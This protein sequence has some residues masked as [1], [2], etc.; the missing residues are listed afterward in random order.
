MKNINKMIYLLAAAAIAQFIFV[1]ISHMGGSTLN[2]HSNHQ[3]VLA[4]DK[5]HVDHLLIE[6]HAQDDKSD[7]SDKDADAMAVR[8]KKK[9]G[10]WFTQAGIPVTENKV[11]HLLEKLAGLKQD[12]PVATSS[13]ALKRFK[14][15]DNDYERL[16][17]L[18]NGD[19]KL[20]ALYLGRGA[21][22]RQT[23]VRSDTQSAVYTVELGVYDVPV[24]SEDWQDKNLLKLSTHE[25]SELK[26]A[27]ITFKPE[28]TPEQTRGTENSSMT[29]WKTSNLPVDKMINQKAIN[30]NLSKLASLSF[31]KILGKEKKTEYGLDKPALIVSLTHKG[32]SREYQFAK[33]NDKED[34][35]LKVSDMEEYFQ[36]SSYTA[37]PLVEGISKA[38]WFM[39]KP[40]DESDES[41]E[42]NDKPKNEPV[43]DP[44]ATPETSKTSDNTAKSND[45]PKSEPVSDP[46][47]TPET[48]KT[49]DNTAKSNDKPKSEPVSD[50]KATPETSKTPDNTAKSNDKPK[51]EPV[52]DPKVI[53]ET[54]K[55]PDNT[56]ES[57]D[58]PKSE[59]VSEAKVNPEASKTLD[60][61]NITATES[62]MSSKTSTNEAKMTAAP[63]NKN[64]N[65][66]QAINN[67]T[68]PVKQEEKKNETAK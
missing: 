26:L 7:K 63:T 33:L 27:D 20:A 49:P 47:A 51:S 53:P 18:K 42:S 37:K 35:V 10:K 28:K 8:L 61:T 62:A 29:I 66:Q 39:D 30:D 46:K 45:K 24:N 54:S 56:G 22:A 44:K 41:S 68:E 32:Q 65:T 64:E 11:E 60:N 19:K 21:G 3:T 12:L 15:A 17:T 50:P 38:K 59:P 31:S 52:S 9:D 67:P 57:N 5:A 48:S 23:H 14:V 6:Q 16:I 55:T 2:S 34:Y 40:K 43:S 4:F 1:I 36:I 25:V 13:S 58:K